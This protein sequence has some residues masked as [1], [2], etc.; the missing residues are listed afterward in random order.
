MRRASA[1]DSPDAYSEGAALASLRRSRWEPNY[2]DPEMMNFGGLGRALTRLKHAMH[3]AVRVG[4]AA[5]LDVDQGRAQF[6]GLAARAAVAD[7]E[8]AAVELD[9]ADRRPRCR[10]QR[11][12]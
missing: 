5:A 3:P 4:G 9:A 12:L 7:R 8:A 1:Q 6:L 2:P 10:R 11:S